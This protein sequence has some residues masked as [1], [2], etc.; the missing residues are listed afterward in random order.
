VPFDD[1]PGAAEIF[2]D[3]RLVRRVACSLRLPQHLPFVYG[4]P[5]Y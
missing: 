1:G 4:N 3:G 5:P 2:I